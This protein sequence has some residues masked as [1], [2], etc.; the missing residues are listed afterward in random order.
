VFQATARQRFSA[1]DFVVL[2][3]TDD[4]WMV[5][6]AGEMRERERFVRV[7]RVNANNVHVR[8]CAKNPI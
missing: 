3:R 4:D 8:V 1:I 5:S 2:K 6:V 7:L